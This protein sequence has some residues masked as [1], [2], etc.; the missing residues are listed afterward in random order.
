MSV[1][2]HE[3]STIT[4]P[5][6]AD[7]SLDWPPHELARVRWVREY[8]PQ[9]EAIGKYPGV[10]ELAGQRH[11]D[12][13]ALLNDLKRAGINADVQLNAAAFDELL[14][15]EHRPTRGLRTVRDDQGVPV[16]VQVQGPG[17]EEWL[18]NDSL[19]AHYRPGTHWWEFRTDRWTEV[20]AF[21]AHWFLWAQRDDARLG[22]SYARPKTREERDPD[23]SRN[24]VVTVPSV[25]TR[26]RLRWEADAETGPAPTALFAFRMQSERPR[27]Y[28]PSGLIVPSMAGDDELA[29]A[30]ARIAELEATLAKRP[31]KG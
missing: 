11:M 9:G 19:S 4:A 3:S 7:L 30:R 28:R 5:A 17:P 26:L 18:P 1:P 8:T 31:A 24:A 20:P 23:E 21:V 6:Q 12:T 2:L 15:D 13:T 27:G 10:A 14:R 29:A 16:G 25:Q 22:A